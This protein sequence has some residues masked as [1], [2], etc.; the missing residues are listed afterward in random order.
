MDR[1]IIADLDG[2]LC[3]SNHRMHLFRE[4]RY[5]EFNSRACE[6]APIEN[7]CNMIRSLKNSDPSEVKVII[8]TAREEKW[9][10]KTV[11]WLKRYDIPW[12]LLHMRPNGDQRSDWQ[13]KEEMFLLKHC[14]KNI[15]FAIEDRKECVNMWRNN[16]ICCLAMEDKTK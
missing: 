3:D 14:N 10:N 1:W 5:D 15:W 8:M 12:D 11:D 2:T 4:K 16:L 6:D 7:I 13:V 9:R